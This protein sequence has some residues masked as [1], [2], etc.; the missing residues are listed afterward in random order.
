MVL[1]MTDLEE[2]VE[3]KRVVTEFCHLYEKSKQ[4]FNGLR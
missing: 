3:E 2:T 1:R 4:L